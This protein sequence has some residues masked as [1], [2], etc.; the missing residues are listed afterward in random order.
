M[1]A[2][3][4]A[5]ALA[6]LAAT[7]LL[8]ACQHAP[9]SGSSTPA[10]PNWTDG[11]QPVALPGK[12]ATA[13]K[14]HLTDGRWVLVAQSERSASMLRRP[15]RIEPD[16]LGRVSFSWKVDALLSDAD[17]QHGD[18]EDAVVR[19]LLAFEGDPSRLSARTRMMFDLAHGL[20]GETPPFATLMYVWD[21]RAAAGSL[22]VNPRSDRIRKIVV[23]SGATHLGQWRSYTRNVREDFVRAFG[24]DPG[25][26]IGVAVMTDTDNTQS[27]AEAWYGEIRFE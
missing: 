22:V 26:L 20:T 12:R 18:T 10:V 7:L 13:Y 8:V 14:T 9:E 11:W 23:E 17:V 1:I 15:V 3:S 2:R 6:C 21:T 27:R 24:E 25:A 5:P 4:L 16:R 19:V